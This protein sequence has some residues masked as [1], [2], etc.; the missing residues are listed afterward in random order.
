MTKRKG[1]ESINRGGIKC[2]HRA[3]HIGDHNGKIVID[4]QGIA[5]AFWPNNISAS[6]DNPIP[7]IPDSFWKWLEGDD[8]ALPWT[9]FR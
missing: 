9:N 1:C 3:G 5:T 2:F 7:G 4:G 8:S 6:D